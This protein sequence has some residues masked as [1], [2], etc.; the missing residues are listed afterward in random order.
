M[1][2]VSRFG[3]GDARAR[4]NAR[5]GARTRAMVKPMGRLFSV[6]NSILSFFTQ[7][8]H[9]ENIKCK[10]KSLVSKGIYAG[11]AVTSD[12]RL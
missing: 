8:H 3:T 6:R 10:A 11:V 2:G 5:A 9:R 4:A 7:S 1:V 12:T